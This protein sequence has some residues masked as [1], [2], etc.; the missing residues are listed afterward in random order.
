[1]MLAS[2]SKSFV[3]VAAMAAVEDGL[4]GLDD[5]ASE[6]LAEWRNDPKKSRI[7]YRHLLSM[8]SGL[9]PGERGTAMRMKSWPDV[10]AVPMESAPGTH[11]VYGPYHINAFGLAL[12]RKLKGE[13]FEAYL[14]RRVL[15]PL[16][17]AVDWRMRCADGHPQLAG[18]AYVTA[19]DWATFGEFLRTGGRGIVRPALLAECA[20]PYATNPAY[21]LTFWLDQPVPPEIVRD[22][23]LL[24]ADMAS[25]IGSDWL[26]R[27]LY[28]AAGAG[29]QRLFVLPSLH[30]VVV[31][32]GSLLASR[33]FQ[34]GTFLSLLLRGRE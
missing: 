34:D 23:P 25:I 30:A 5:R 6:S 2:G 13:T 11:Y 14:K 3:G 8:S 22:V 29:K 4:L 16:K 21:G 12:E 9:T 32:Q 31:R 33:G 20:R 15:D 10:A 28:M 17:I 24:R 1:M 26:P 19:R 18:G 7:T 27:D